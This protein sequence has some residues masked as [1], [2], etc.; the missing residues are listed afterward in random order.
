[1]TY[2]TEKSTVLVRDR[3]LITIKF[4]PQIDPNETEYS[5][6]QPLFVFGEQVT[7]GNNPSTPL[8]ICGMELVVSKTSSG[9]L[10]NQPYWKY[11]LSDAPT[12]IL[13]NTV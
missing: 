5:Y 6:P 9:Q 13:S 1:M 10:L 7:Q 2:T 11:K 12:L 4:A 3:Q 8:T